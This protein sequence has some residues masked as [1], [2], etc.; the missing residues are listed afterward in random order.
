MATEEQTTAVA[1]Q[2][3]PEEQ[4]TAGAG[5]AA[6]GAG[7]SLPGTAE[8]QALVAAYPGS[9][10]NPLPAGAFYDAVKAFK[11]AYNIG[12]NLGDTSGPNGD[13]PST[14]AG[15]LQHNGN[16]DQATADAVSATGATAPAVCTAGGGGQPVQPNNNNQQVTTTSSGW[17]W[18]VKA[19]LWAIALGGAVGLGLWLWKTFGSSRPMAAEPKRKR[20]KRTSKKR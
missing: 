18:Y 12:I 2:E 6:T 20:G 3:Q 16:Y 19:I 17:P 5:A 8:A 10:T 1:E 11:V 15:Y 7:A 9:C 14:T 13:G 4:R